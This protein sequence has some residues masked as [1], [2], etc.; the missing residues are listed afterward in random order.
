MALADDNHSKTRQ[1][2]LDALNT[3]VYAAK[4][5]GKI[6]ADIINNITRG[7]LFKKIFM[8]DKKLMKNI[9]F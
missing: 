6:D 2:A 9:N 1:Y 4:K 5:S 3:L 8:N 7:I